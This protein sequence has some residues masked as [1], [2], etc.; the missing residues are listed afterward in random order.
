MWG[1]WRGETESVRRVV[2]GKCG[3][4][5]R[6]RERERDMGARV[7]REGVERE[8]NQLRERTNR[9]KARQEP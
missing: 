3:G 4:R 6:D 9:T 7:V 5:N 2:L 8:G 1:G